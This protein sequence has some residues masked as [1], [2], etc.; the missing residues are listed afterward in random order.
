[1]S[2]AHTYNPVTH[3]YV[4]SAED[5]GYTPANATH[6]DLPPRPWGRQWPR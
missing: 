6:A 1:M 3:D 4:S 2:V 5:F